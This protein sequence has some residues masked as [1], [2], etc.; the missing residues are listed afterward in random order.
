MLTVAHAINLLRF[1]SFTHGGEGRGDP[2]VPIVDA[3]K[4][5][6]N[7]I[8]GSVSVAFL[9]YAIFRALHIGR[10]EARYS[11]RKSRK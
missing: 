2:A 10:R 11:F 9:I 5:E 8:F 7:C 3:K 6:D 4:R 1:T